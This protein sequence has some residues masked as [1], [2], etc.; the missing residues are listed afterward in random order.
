MAHLMSNFSAILLL[1]PDIEKRLGYQQMLTM[2]AVGFAVTGVVNSA[3]FGASIVGVNSVVFS[4]LILY[5]D[6]FFSFSNRAEQVVPL[7]NFMLVVFWSAKEIASSMSGGTTAGLAHIIGGVA[8]GEFRSM[9]LSI[10]G[11]FFICRM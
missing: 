5:T 2:F 4:L 10:Y 3:I 7:T 9:Y 1:G 8:A 11:W 6:N